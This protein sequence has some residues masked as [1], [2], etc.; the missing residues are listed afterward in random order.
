M[1]TFL[2]DNAGHRVP[3]ADAP[4]PIAASGQTLTNGT[5]LA[6]GTAT[7]VAGATYAFTSMILGGFIFGIAATTTPAN[8]IW[9]CPIYGTIIIT[10]PNGV[11]TLH[12]A[13]NV[14]SGVGYLR[15]LSE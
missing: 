13:T 9:A 10:I 8:I 12:Y 4:D 2:S 6:N 5:A 15:K 14:N 11:T 3:P 7:V 1:E